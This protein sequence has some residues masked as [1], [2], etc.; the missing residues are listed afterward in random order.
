MSRKTDSADSKR[1]GRRRRR[2]IVLI[3]VTAV[4]AFATV[5]LASPMLIP[6]PLPV[7]DTLGGDIRL[8]STLGDELAL[9]SLRGEIVLLNF[10]YTQCPDVC[11]TV[12]ARLRALLLDLEALDIEA[13]PLFVTLDPERDDLATLEQYLDHFHPDLVGLRG[14]AAQTAAVAERYQV[15]YQREAMNSGL[16]YGF[17]HSVEI[18]LID[19]RGRVRATFG[20]NVPLPDMVR[21]VRRL[22]GEGAS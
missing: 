13:R 9:D 16:D 7:L 4:L 5:R 21:T 19:P 10:G 6:E 11:P 14:T 1:R 22:A 2:R 12:L 20:G 15:F 3:V 8:P 18:Y 17:T